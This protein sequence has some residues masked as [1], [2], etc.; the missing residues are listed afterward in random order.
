M[1]KTLRSL[2][3]LSLAVA[4]GVSLFGFGPRLRERDPNPTFARWRASLAD[5]SPRRC[6]EA[7]S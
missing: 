1:R 6:Q 2:A 5:W 7:S 4:V 3:P